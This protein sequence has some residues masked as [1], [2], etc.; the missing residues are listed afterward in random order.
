MNKPDSE[1]ASGVCRVLN[2]RDVGASVTELAGS[3]LLPAGRLLRSGS[4]RDVNS[5]T[6]VGEPRTIISLQ[7]RPDPPCASA[8]TFHCPAPAQGANVYNAEAWAIR[9][10]LK[11]TLRHLTGDIGCPV[12]IHCLSGV[13]RT[14]VVIASLL[15][16][17]GLPDELI[18]AEC[19][20]SGG[21]PEGDSIRAFL[22]DVGDVRKYFRGL[23]LAT[24]RE[25]LGGQAAERGPDTT[26][27]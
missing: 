2:Y 13:D 6:E 1:S 22:R 15:R 21:A 12:L 26:A 9:A 16:V 3:P 4:I 20:L 7:T 27:A 25:T 8:A 17:A 5:L 24:L 10:W 19:R 23:D 11:T 14:G 18:I